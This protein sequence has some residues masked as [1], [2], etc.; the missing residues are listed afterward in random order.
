MFPPGV[1]GF[2]TVVESEAYWIPVCSGGGVPSPSVEFAL[3]LFGIKASFGCFRVGGNQPS[4]WTASVGK[5]E[6]FAGAKSGKNGG[7][8]SRQFNGSDGRHD[9]P[10]VERTAEFY[11]KVG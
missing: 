6:F 5:Q 7:K 10:V 4:H 9:Y 1:H 2:S 8:P 3:P 11:R